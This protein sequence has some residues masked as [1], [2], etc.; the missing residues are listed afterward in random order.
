MRQPDL[1]L[2]NYMHSCAIIFLPQLVAERRRPV[3]SI[4]SDVVIFV[5]SFLMADSYISKPTFIEN[6]AALLVIRTGFAFVYINTAERK[7]KEGTIQQ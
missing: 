6:D 2:A 5:Y 4:A 1:Y 3:I 7:K